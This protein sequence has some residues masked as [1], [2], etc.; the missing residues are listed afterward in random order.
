MPKNPVFPQ[1]VV[2]LNIS[3]YFSDEY[4]DERPLMYVYHIA[5]NSITESQLD[6]KHNYRSAWVSL[7][8]A[9]CLLL[10]PLGEVL[11]LHRSF[12]IELWRKHIRANPNSAVIKFTGNDGF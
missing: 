2:S 4:A 5:T 12:P 10:S 8:G 9:N 1:Y 3:T 7:N 6:G 11:L